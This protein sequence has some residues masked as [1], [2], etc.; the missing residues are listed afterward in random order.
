MNAPLITALRKPLPLI[1]SV[2]L[3]VLGVALTALALRAQ[4]QSNTATAA[5][6]PNCF[7]DNWPPTNQT[8]KDQLVKV[9][10]KALKDSAKPGTPQDQS[11]PDLRKILL[12]TKNNFKAPKDKIR[13]RLDTEY[14]NNKIKF[15]K[16]LVIIFYEA[17]AGTAPTPAPTATATEQA[18]ALRC[19]LLHPNHCYI[20]VYLEPVSSSVTN[21]SLKNNM[22]CCYDPY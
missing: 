7:V 1:A 3:I 4:A 11:G 6:I 22:M 18:N 8:D 13:Q 21:P 15:P 19:A 12:D 2:V 14:P 16:Y 20:V 17:E 5:H 10:E 9:F